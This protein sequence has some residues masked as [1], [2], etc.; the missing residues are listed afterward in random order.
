MKQMIII[1][2]LV[3]MYFP[4]RRL[5]LPFILRPPLVDLCLLIQDMRV[6]SQWKVLQQLQM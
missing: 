5:L 4:Q 3:T 6:L 1:L 2:T